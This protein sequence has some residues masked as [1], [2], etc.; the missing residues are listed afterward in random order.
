MKKIIFYLICVLFFG[1]SPNLLAQS[2]AM[3]H[4]KV[5]VAGTT[6]TIPKVYIE[7]RRNGI[8]VLKAQS[9]EEGYYYIHLDAG[10]YTF[11]FNK[12]NCETTV[13]EGVMLN[14]GRYSKLNLALN[15]NSNF[16][17]GGPVCQYKQPLVE[18]D[19]TTNST[20][21]TGEQLRGNF[22]WRGF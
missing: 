21:Y 22:W 6:E 5:T 14:S 2:Q 8:S 4:G 3:L 16:S 7:V 19:N 1:A 20:I 10:T 17:C 18:E 12:M 13:V 15:P 9:D 11:I